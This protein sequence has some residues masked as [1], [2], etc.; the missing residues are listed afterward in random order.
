M[1]ENFKKQSKSNKI[2]GAKMPKRTLSAMGNEELGLLS[3]TN[4]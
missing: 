2:K 4:S 3:D 1:M